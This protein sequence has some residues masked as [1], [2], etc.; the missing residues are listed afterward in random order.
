LGLTA[1]ASP[2]LP[3]RPTPALVRVA[4]DDLTQLLLLDLA[5]AYAN[6]NPTVVVAPDLR[7]PQ[8]LTATLATGQDDLALTIAPDH[9]LFA[10]PLGYLPFVVVVHPSNGVTSLSVAQ[11]QGLFSGQAADWGQVA[12]AGA[13]SAGAVQV[14]TRGP[15]T[16]ADAAFA[17][18]LGAFSPPAAAQVAPT[19][20]AMRALVSQDPAAVGYLIGPEV[21]TSVKVVPVLGAGGAPATLRLLVVAQAAGE[22]SG[23]ARDFLAWAQSADGQTAVARRHVALK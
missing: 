4:V 2:T 3:P 20:A 21:D 23:A 17:A 5:A 6:V 12:G 16:A 8:A 13:G 18:A 15:G 9:S 10:T 22:P 11:A 14:V 19:W 7:S 1:C